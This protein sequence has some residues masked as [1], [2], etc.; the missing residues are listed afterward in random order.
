MVAIVQSQH[1]Y[2]KKAEEKKELSELLSVDEFGRLIGAD[3]ILRQP[4]HRPRKPFAGNWLVLS[5]FLLVTASV[6]GI[7]LLLSLHDSEYVTSEWVSFGLLCLTLILP[8]LFFFAVMRS[9]LR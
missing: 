8:L 5:F 3:H 2:M 9:L 1:Y 7:S 4:H 6:S